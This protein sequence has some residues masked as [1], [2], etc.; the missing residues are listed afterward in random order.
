MIKYLTQRKLFQRLSSQ[1]IST[2]FTVSLFGNISKLGLSF[3]SG[4]IIARGLGPAEYGDFAFLLTSFIAI[5][6]LLDVGTSQAFYTFISKRKRSFS[7]YSYYFGWMVLQFIIT[8]AFVWLL[9]PDSL[10][11]KMWVGHSRNI[12][13]LAFIASFSMSQIWEFATSIGESIRDTF[14]V[15]LRNLALAAVYLLIL[16][17]LL[18]Y[19]KINITNIYFSIIFLY[20]SFSFIYINKIKR[21]IFLHDD[22]STFKNVFN[23]FKE[24]CSPLVIYAWFGF[25]YVFADNWLLQHFGGSTQQGFYAIGMRFSALSLI[26]TTSILRIFWKEIAE[27]TER[28][29]HEKIKKLYKRTSRLLYFSGAVLSCFLIP[30]SK[31]I[32]VWLLGPGFEYAWIPLMLLFLY[33]LH[34]SLGQ[35]AGAFFLATG[36]TKIHR[37]IGLAMMVMSLPVSYL[38]LANPDSQVP[39]LGLG[40]MG[41]AAKMLIL[42]FFEINVK[43]FIISKI[44]LISFD[45]LYQ[46]TTVV[47]LAMCGFASKILAGGLLTFVGTS[48]IPIIW[49][50]LSGITYL[51]LV[52]SILLLM[53]F[54]ID[55]TRKELLD[56]IKVFRYSLSYR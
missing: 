9:C 45:W 21:Q 13:I 23:E 53:P 49:F 4:L 17:V 43:I 14:F 42:Q 56:K 22:E 38:L 28:N 29:E 20:L 25:I 12:I 31:E 32:L 52:F 54:L 15:Q 34:Q 51:L 2:R 26:A 6:Q 30:F 33:P 3:L 55:I 35:I 19:K 41:L 47:I 48:K 40:A 10:R 50:G 5:R 36:R 44:L 16:V 7:F 11:A 27:A 39:G 46:F 1:D 8:L 24:Y 18:K 37:N